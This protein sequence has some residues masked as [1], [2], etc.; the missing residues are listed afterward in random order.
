MSRIVTRALLIATAALTINTAANAAYFV[1]PYLSY[2]GE[3]VD[4]LILNGD[5]SSSQSFS[6]GFVSLQSEANLSDGTVK[7]YLDMSGPSTSF[8]IAAGVIGE[9]IRYF[10]ETGTDVEFNF[11]I[12]GTI[13]AYQD[14]LGGT[15]P[16][17]DRQ[18]LINA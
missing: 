17:G 14:L 9:R 5:T 11:N 4:G 8:G 15:E 2:D 10:G 13:S 6:N 12:D 3:I 18:I 1:R 7:A 16:A